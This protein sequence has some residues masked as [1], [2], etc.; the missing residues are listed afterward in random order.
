MKIY[1]FV[2][3]FKFNNLN[4]LDHTDAHLDAHKLGYKY[5]IYLA[6]AL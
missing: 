1:P 5:L 2:S 4:Y 3:L 6:F